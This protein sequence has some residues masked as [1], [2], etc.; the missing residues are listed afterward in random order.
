MIHPHDS[1]HR[2]YIIVRIRLPAPV[3]TEME[4]AM[5]VNRSAPSSHF[6]KRQFPFDLI[7]FC[8]SIL[9][10]FYFFFFFGSIYKARY[11]G[12]SGSFKRIFGFY[13]RIKRRAIDQS[14]G[15]YAKDSV[16]G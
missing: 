8:R 2:T 1:L 3:S 13:R 5:K 4:R 12:N 15:I 9:F 10:L 11:S 6:I 7:T 14:A 16:C